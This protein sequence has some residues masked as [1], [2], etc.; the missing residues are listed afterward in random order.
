MSR[1]DSD[2]DILIRRER[3]GLPV[4]EDEASAAILRATAGYAGFVAER[5]REDAI[6]KVTIRMME[7]WVEGS[8]DLA[9]TKAYLPKSMLN[10]GRDVHRAERRKREVSLATPVADGADLGDTLRATDPSPADRAHLRDL[11][12]RLPIEAAALRKYL[13]QARPVVREIEAL[14]RLGLTRAEIARILRDAGYDITKD[15]VRKIVSRDLQQRFP[16]LRELW[17]NRAPDG[18]ATAAGNRARR[19]AAE[20][21][22]RRALDRADDTVVLIARLRRTTSRDWSMIAG[23]VQMATGQLTTATDVRTRWSEFVASLS[24]TARRCAP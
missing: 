22:F 18:A 24:P 3:S 21:E 19:H 4:S 7:A 14:S 1:M 13:D 20:A 8:R 15:N 10:A 6:Q 23:Q 17:A 2:L 9:R 5:E 11:L 12:S 16:I